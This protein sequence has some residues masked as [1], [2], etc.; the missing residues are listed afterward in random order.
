MGRHDE[1]DGEMRKER[2]EKSKHKHKEKDSH[3]ENSHK[4][5]EKREKK[6]DTVAA[7]PGEEAETAIGLPLP[8]RSGATGAGNETDGKEE[9]RKSTDDRHGGQPDG[10][11]K[12]KS[13]RLPREK[14]GTR[15]RARQSDKERDS[16]R[17]KDGDRH[18]QKERDG[19]EGSR[20]SEIETRKD[21][22]DERDRNER[23]RHDNDRDRRK[24]DKDTDAKEDSH[25]RERRD[26]D[27]DREER[28]SGV[29]LGEP[30]KDG[31]SAAAASVSV[32]ADPEGDYMDED[33]PGPPPAA[34][35]EA[36]SAQEPF[37]EDIKPQVQESGGEIS[38]SIEETNRSASQ[39]AAWPVIFIIDALLHRWP[40]C[41]HPMTKLCAPDLCCCVY[42]QGA[43]FPGPEAA[44]SGD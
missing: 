43:H 28:T 25:R 40:A 34:P 41:V 30:E 3:K 35:A 22:N 7:K 6:D 4:H 26:R 27:R 36:A 13:E 33:L 8:P 20:R 44:F 31:R 19:G 14:E 29:K 9:V 1:E 11:S 38:M 17:E 16:R 5:K 18:R 37:A 2:K 10:A 23:R 15:D 12:E 21:R 32:A 39:H 24:D 42:V